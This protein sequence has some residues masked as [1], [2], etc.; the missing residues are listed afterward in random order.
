MTR[1]E[2]A[3]AASLRALTTEAQELGILIDSD[4]DSITIRPEGGDTDE[5]DV[6]IA[7]VGITL[8]AREAGQ[9]W[10]WHGSLPEYIAE[11]QLTNN[12]SL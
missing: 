11:R 6:V 3:A 9:R 10:P 7:L 5:G 12:W 1:H 4:E 2:A 8:V